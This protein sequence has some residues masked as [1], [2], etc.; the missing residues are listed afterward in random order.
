MNKGP[1]ITFL[2][3]VGFILF[4]IGS[5]HWYASQLIPREVIHYQE[6]MK[7]FN[8]QEYKEKFL[9]VYPEVKGKNYTELLDWLSSKLHYPQ[10]DSER[11]QEVWDWKVKSEGRP[12]DPLDILQ[13]PWRVTETKVYS[14]PFRTE[15]IARALGRC[16]EFSLVY[17][18]LLLIN[19]YDCRILMGWYSDG[20]HV[21]VEVYAITGYQ[22][23]KDFR[24]QGNEPLYVPEYQWLTIDPTD[25][26]SFREYNP[27]EPWENCSKIS[28]SKK[29]WGDRIWDSVYRI[30]L[31]NIEKVTK[32]YNEG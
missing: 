31:E 16:G 21:W 3:V 28:T 25:A 22:I 6:L 2:L 19:D 8:T 1:I 20:D 9:K 17:I 7:K 12:E 13:S 18:Q 10:A 32:E 5:A 14:E 27:S 30:S 29:L 11:D 26:S 15:T 4:F 24:G 23:N